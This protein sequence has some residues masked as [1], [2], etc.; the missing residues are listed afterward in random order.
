MS[1]M[2]LDVWRAA[3]AR[4][5][6]FSGESA[7]YVALGLCEELG[8]GPRAIDL[9]AVELCDDGALRVVAGE[10]CSGES[11]E[12]SVRSLLRQLLGVASSPGPALHRAAERDAGA[13]VDAL[14][15]ELKKALIPVNRQAAR[16]A[17]LR[18]CRETTRAVATGQLAAAPSEVVVEAAAGP[19]PSVSRPLPSTPALSSTPVLPSPAP[20]PA[21]VVTPPPLPVSVA[22]PPAVAVPTQAVAE[23][24]VDLS[25]FPLEAEQLTSPETVV[26]RIR[27]RVRPSPPPL[28][29]SDR[30]SSTP[31]IGSVESAPEAPARVV[32]TPSPPPLPLFPEATERAPEVRQ[33]FAE[34][35]DLCASAID[36]VPVV[37]IVERPAPAVEPI[38]PPA[39]VEVEAEMS[40]SEASAQPLADLEAEERAIAVAL[41]I[42]EPA[43]PA[44]LNESPAL[45]VGVHVEDSEEAAEPVDDDDLETRPLLGRLPPTPYPGL[46]PK[47]SDV[48]ELARGFQVGGAVDETEL[49]RELKALAGVDLTPAQPLAG[50]PR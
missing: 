43:E 18:L 13:G 50:G 35:F 22:P 6:P 40:A 30:H 10:P 20:A 12:G 2:L 3:R 39:E 49:R 36:A 25:V 8:R 14:S 26:A 9:Q 44:E 41:A 5:V 47:A 37:E 27:H 7:G 17:L 16:R 11:A 1:V 21:R 24:E 38:P 4:S 28:P 48:A 23:P 34:P 31:R 46:P 32:R 15:T 42:A 33:F 45:I 29:R 19:S